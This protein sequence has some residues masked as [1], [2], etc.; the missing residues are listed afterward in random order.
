MVVRVNDV[1]LINL[2]TDIDNIGDASNQDMVITP[3]L[4]TPYKSMP[5]LSREFD[6]KIQEL[7]TPFGDGKKIIQT[8]TTIAD[9][10]ALD[11]WPGRVVEVMGYH[12]PR[13][14]VYARPYKGGGRFYYDPS[15]SGINDGGVNINGW[16]RLGWEH[17]DVTMFGAVGDKETDDS[18]AFINTVTFVYNHTKVPSIITN[19]IATVSIHIPAS[20]G[21]GYRLAQ[22]RSL[23]PEFS[24]MRAIGLTFIGSGYPVINFDYDGDD[25]LAYNNNRFL[26]TKFENLFF[27]CDSAQ[28]KFMYSNGNGGS[29]DYTFNNC[30]WDGQWQKLFVLRGFDNNSEWVWNKSNVSAHIRDTMM[31]VADSDQ[32]LNYWFNNC[33][34]W[35]YDGQCIRASKGGHF[36]FINCDWSGIQ[37]TR[38][39]C[40]STN[41]KYLFELTGTSHAR[42]VCDFRIIGGRFELKKSYNP[43]GTENTTTPSINARLLYTEWNQ[44]NI[45]LS[46]DASSTVLDVFDNE[47][48]IE[49]ATSPADPGPILSVHDSHL[50][51]KI[52]IRSGTSGF[53]QRKI[54]TFVNTTFLGIN[55]KKPSDF[56]DLVPNDQ[57]A[58]V[59]SVS[60]TACRSGAPVFETP[61][62]K[63]TAWDLVLGNKSSVHA[64]SRKNTAFFQGDVYG[65]NPINNVKAYLQLPPNSIVTHIYIENTGEGG[66]SSALARWA[67]ADE[68]KGEIFAM[69]EGKTL[70]TSFAES[71]HLAVKTTTGLLSLYDTANSGVQSTT[72]EF[73]CWVEYVS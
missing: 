45:E 71:K 63:L 40:T 72:S 21:G 4:G 57:S 14:L 20:E 64:I 70:R 46:I 7:T 17:I 73:R 22:P 68:V 42:G 48:L 30:N 33:K 39:M 16:V 55:N 38:S 6:E 15:K 65:N 23:I 3:R 53:N 67:V 2:K 28:S 13:Y 52:K 9:M 25:Y 32:F 47:N 26:I 18:Q 61:Q 1:D 12:A 59:G 58:G 60:L 62:L 19:P 5:M 66:D 37:G 41:G 43:D 50:V 10:L 27:T 31:D 11:T 24:G 35:L 49:I 44:G 56:F 29:Q 34:L 54:H 36:K 8:V 69:T 51:G